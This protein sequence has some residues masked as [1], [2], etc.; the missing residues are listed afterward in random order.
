MGRPGDAQFFSSASVSSFSKVAKHHASRARK[1][2]SPEH[3]EVRPGGRGTNSTG[4]T[5]GGRT[6]TWATEPP[7]LRP[8]RR[9][10]PRGVYLTG[11]VGGVPTTLVSPSYRRSRW[12]WISGLI[13]VWDGS[14]AGA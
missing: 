12:N 1:M 2:T 13:I 11:R 9:H 5:N 4:W 7:E 6:A 14:L 3:F 8:H 10:D